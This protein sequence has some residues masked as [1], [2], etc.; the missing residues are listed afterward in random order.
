MYF[1]AIIWFALNL[2][3][4]INNYLLF[5]LTHLN[6]Y[7]IKLL[8]S[9]RINEIY[10]FCNFNY[11]YRVRKLTFFFQLVLISGMVIHSSCLI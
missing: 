8:K 9:S 6:K 5:L 4:A 3:R 7:L 11:L 10:G 1:I 2:L